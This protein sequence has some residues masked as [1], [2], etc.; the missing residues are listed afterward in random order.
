M[1]LPSSVTPGALSPRFSAAA[2][3]AVYSWNRSAEQRPQDAA[4][5][6]PVRRVAGATHSTQP[7]EG[8]TSLVGAQPQRLLLPDTHYSL[9]CP[10]HQWCHAAWQTPGG[11]R[12]AACHPQPW[13]P[14]HPESSRL[15]GRLQVKVQ[16]NMNADKRCD[17]SC[18]EVNC[19]SQPHSA[20]SF[21]RMLPKKHPNPLHF[22]APPTLCQAVP[23]G[24]V[25]RRLHFT[26][27]QAIHLQRQTKGQQGWRSN[28]SADACSMCMRRAG[29]AAKPPR[30]SRAIRPHQ[31]TSLQASFHS[32][33]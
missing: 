30:D 31:C 6:P 1:S 18:R 5:N 12:P 25:C 27:G 22:T 11:G 14:A 33:L 32:P 4:T 26:G 24:G 7:L 8:Q 29:R 23:A 20:C 2:R 28:N 15:R 10:P 16:R 21:Q 9:P 3:L 13:P 17:G 19:R